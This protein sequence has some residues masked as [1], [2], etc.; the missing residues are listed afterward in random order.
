MNT[1][2]IPLAAAIAAAFA[3]TWL[4]PKTLFAQSSPATPI[5]VL[6]TSASGAE[7]QLPG[8]D[9]NLG[10]AGLSP[11]QVVT[12]TLQFPQQ[13][14]KGQPVSVSSLD[15]GSLSS[16]DGASD[17]KVSED[18]TAPF[19]FHAGHQP[20]LYRLI[21]GFGTALYHLEFYV[22]DLQNTERNP[23]RVRVVE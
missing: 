21:I 19:Q 10:R 20:G 4:L 12:V 15:G 22:L 14:M 7:R 11:E 6:V 13:T 2:N 9:Y 16:V 5:A 18:G 23:P 8:A 1:K 17:L 3:M